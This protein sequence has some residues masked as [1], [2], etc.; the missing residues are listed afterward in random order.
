MAVVGC[1][2]DS[3]ALAEQLARYHQ[4][5]STA[6]RIERH[7]RGAVVAFASGVDVGLLERTLTQERACCSFLVLDYDSVRRELSLDTDADGQDALDAIMAAITAGFVAGSRS[8]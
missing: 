2:L 4:L 7:V 5:G 1:R 6:V 3:Q 8:G